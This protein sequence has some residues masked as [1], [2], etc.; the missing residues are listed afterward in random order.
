M[1]GQELPYHQIP[2]YPEDYGSG[3]IVARMIDGL[4]FRYYWATEGL[5]PQDLAYKPS[6]DGRSVLETLQHI[7]GMSE[8]VLETPKGEPSLRPKD[9]TNMTFE[10]LR[11]G[12]LDNLFSASNLL[13]GQNKDIDTCAN[14]LEPTV[15]SD[16]ASN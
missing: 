10:E 6:E 13:K 9:F 12:T 1:N 8:T 15:L 11:K 4:G 16:S 3:N 14:L 5:R 7:Y 2:E